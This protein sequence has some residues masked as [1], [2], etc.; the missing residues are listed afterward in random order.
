MFSPRVT[1]LVWAMLLAWSTSALIILG[2]IGRDAGQ[3]GLGNSCDLLRALIYCGCLRFA[4]KCCLGA[5]NRLYTRRAIALL[6]AF[7]VPIQGF[8]GVAMGLRGPAHFHT[9]TDHFSGARHWHGDIERHHHAAEAGVVEI[10]DGDDLGHA[11]L[12]AGENKRAGYGTL[13]TLMTMTFVFPAHPR[14]NVALA[15]HSIRL[16]VHFPGIPEKPPRSPSDL[17]KLTTS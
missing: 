10:D 14:A 5:R 6:I 15:T 9:H 8:A 16:T 7:A 13:D 1:H 4:W 11:A 3:G 2:D 12:A 17:S